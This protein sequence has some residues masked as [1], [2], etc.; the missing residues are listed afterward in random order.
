MK[1]LLGNRFATKI[2]LVILIVSLIPSIFNSIFYYVSSSNVIKENVRESSLQIARQAADS[3]SYIF[4]V[5]SDTSNLVYSNETIQDI[6]EQDI[7]GEASYASREQN[8]DYITSL[9]NSTVYSNSF[10]RYIYILRESGKSWGS[11]TFSEHKLSQYKFENLSWV[12]GAKEQ[13]GKLVWEGLQFERFSGAGEATEYVLPI[14]RTMQD[15]DDLSDLSYIQ[16]YLDGNAILEKI[17]TIT[18]GKTGRFF[19]VNNQGEIMIDPVI[20]NINKTISNP[21]LS[22]Y[23]LNSDALEFEYE[24]K[25]IK[26]YGVKQPLTNGWTIIGVVPVDEITGELSKIQRTSVFTSTIL[27]AIVIIIGFVV[28]TRVTKPIKVLTNQMKLVGEGNFKARTSVD[29]SDE[30][31]MMSNQFNVMTQQVEQLMDQVKKEQIQKRDADLRAVKHRINPH[32]LFN[33]LS[34]IRW[35]VKF[36]QYDRANSALVALSRLLEANMGKKGTFVTVDEEIDFVKKFIELL[37]IRY[38]QS[39]HL[40][41]KIDAGVAD[42]KIPQMLL[43]PIVEN[44]IFHGIVPTANTGKIEIYGRQLA[45]GIELSVYDN[46]IG[47]KEERIEQIITESKQDKSIVGIGLLHVFESIDLYYSPDS[48]VNIYSNAG[49][50]MVKIILIPKK[51]RWDHE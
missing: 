30:I 21:A 32:F 45:E 9:L 26:H 33:S 20:E 28:A 41:V 24:E 12:A 19:V 49:G 36:N 25:G 34:T 46:G 6:V 16:V 8:N 43:Q 22:Q 1:K 11:G 39:F 5:G 14:T 40:N 3:L 15:F 37:E 17:K 4:S 10:V 23:V 38:E 13:D 42:Y 18:L 29:T 50:T 44:A 47:M 51:Q 35:L 27:A 2:V 48:T 31:G 7:E